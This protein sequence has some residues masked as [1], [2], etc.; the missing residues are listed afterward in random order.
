VDNSKIVFEGAEPSREPVA[1]RLST[2]QRT[3]VMAHEPEG[4]RPCRM[5]VQGTERGA[6][7]L[8]KQ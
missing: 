8:R 2:F 7:K 1:K 5:V 3:L 6:T 4:L